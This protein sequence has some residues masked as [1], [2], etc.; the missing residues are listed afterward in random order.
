MSGLLRT[1]G[2]NNHPISEDISRE[3]QARIYSGKLKH[4]ERLIERKLAAK[5]N[6]NSLR[7]LRQLNNATN[8]TE[9][10]GRNK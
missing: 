2:S 7:Y 1:D 3:L 8:Q 10:R 5:R 9:G 4:G 6:R